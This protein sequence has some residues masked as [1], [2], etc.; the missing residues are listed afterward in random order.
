MP[1]FDREPCPVEVPIVRGGYSIP[2]RGNVLAVRK[3]DF[4]VWITP[5]QLNG[6]FGCFVR[7]EDGAQVIDRMKGL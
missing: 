1:T 2:Y 3:R 7:V 4:S 5:Q 6:R